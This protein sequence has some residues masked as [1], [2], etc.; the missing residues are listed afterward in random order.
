MPVRQNE[1][2]HAAHPFAF[3]LPRFGASSR[4]WC[5]WPPSLPA[6]SPP[7]PRP[8]FFAT[9]ICPDISVPVP[10]SRLLSPFS[11]SLSPHLWCPLCVRVGEGGRALDRCV[12]S[13]R[14]ARGGDGGGGEGSGGP[15]AKMDVCAQADLRPAPA[16]TPHETPTWVEVVILVHL[17]SLPLSPAA[18]LSYL[19]LSPPVICPFAL[20]SHCGALAQALQ[21]LGTPPACSSRLFLRPPFPSPC[22]AR[23]H[24]SLLQ[25]RLPSLWRISGTLP[26]PSSQRCMCACVY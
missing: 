8:L 14:N 12:S 10:L 15:L 4:A 5:A 9:I 11:L 20:S 1:M 23:H 6:C 24:S 19:D 16:Y 2:G 3:L 26:P 21:A 22:R 13:E 18:Q 17:S 25:S 7:P